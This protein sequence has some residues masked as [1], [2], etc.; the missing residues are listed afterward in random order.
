MSIH[1]GMKIKR[2]KPGAKDSFLSARRANQAVDVI[3]ALLNLTIVRGSSDYVTYS[4]SRVVISIREE[5]AE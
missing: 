2:A 3:N 5:A 1:A 4:D